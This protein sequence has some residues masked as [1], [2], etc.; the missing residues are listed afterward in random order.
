MPEVSTFRLYLLRAM[1]LLIAV[2]LGF[3]IWPSL[4]HHSNAWALK[5]GDT[6]SIKACMMGVIICPIAIPWPY[7]L[8]QFARARGD[9]W[10]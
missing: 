8:A 4:I 7:A 5:N 9:R 10:R 6:L 3:I 1:Y 2:G